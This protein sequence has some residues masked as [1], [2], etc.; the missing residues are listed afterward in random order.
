[1]C[2]HIRPKVS[3]ICLLVILSGTLSLYSCSNHKN[4]SANQSTSSKMI[5]TSAGINLV[6]YNLCVGDSTNKKYYKH[7]ESTTETNLYGDYGNNYHLTI[8]SNNQIGSIELISSSVFTCDNLRVGLTKSAFSTV[9]PDIT[10]SDSVV[11][12]GLTNA[13][14]KVTFN[15][16]GI[17][18]SIVITYAYT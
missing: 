1:M 3:I 15:N 2:K 12:I 13:I 17:I 18:S 6:S 10:V 7:I 9:Y 5:S 11:E 14:E 16:S 8:D 4:S